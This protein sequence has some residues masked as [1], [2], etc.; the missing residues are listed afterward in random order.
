MRHFN[1]VNKQRGSLLVV[2]TI[3][4]SLIGLAVLVSRLSPQEY[5][6]AHERQTYVHLNEAKRALIGYAVSNHPI[7][8]VNAETDEDVRPGELPCPDSDGDGD[9]DANDRLGSGCRTL[10]GWFPYKELGIG[11]AVD[12]RGGANERLWYIVTDA[13]ANKTTASAEVTLNSD[14]LGEVEVDSA[15][16]RFAA[17]LIAP[18]VEQGL[19]SR[20]VSDDFANIGA[21]LDDDNGDG[22][23]RYVSYHNNNFNDVILTIS[24]DEIMRVVELRAIKE[25]RD[26]LQNFYDENDFYP[27][28]EADRN[29][30]GDTGTS[31]TVRSAFLPLGTNDISGSDCPYEDELEDDFIDRLP[32]WFI[33]NNWGSVIWYAVSD[34]CVGTAANNCAS[35]GT[36]LNVNGN[37]QVR[38]AV[39]AAGQK[40][41]QSN[42]NGAVF[43]PTRPGNAN[44]CE[45][46]DS[47]ENTNADDVFVQLK[48]NNSFNDQF[49][50]INE[51]PP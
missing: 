48:R 6:M 1:S 45:Y 36:L 21:Y 38:V 30:D 51:P 42:C 25:A 29:C 34:T 50:T 23:N 43:L 44:I 35:S 47:E 8:A 24:V 37:N 39:A 7:G 40:L 14:S 22:D 10:A 3:F 16:N 18:G 17:I 19:Q 13:F 12:V 26:A 41:S 15:Q 49:V 32:A 46:L 2:L 33:E 28:A 9:V 11:E 20:T 4:L 5:A 31:L 27:Y